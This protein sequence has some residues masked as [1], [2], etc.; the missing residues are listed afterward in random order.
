MALEKLAHRQ[1]I[2]LVIRI[3][4]C[5]QQHTRLCRTPILC[6]WEC[7]TNSHGKK[8]NIKN[9]DIPNATGGRRQKW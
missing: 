2:A 8:R 1:R 5:N 9:K 6:I 3:W 4:K 7:P